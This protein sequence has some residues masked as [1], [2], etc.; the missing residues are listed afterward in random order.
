MTVMIDANKR[1]LKLLDGI[2]KAL[3]EN[4][5][6]EAYDLGF[7]ENKAFFSSRLQDVKSGKSTLVSHE[8]M[9]ERIE[10]RIDKK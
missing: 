8:D 10:S 9:W 3:K 1:Q 2:L 6:I 5:A 4:D 7:E